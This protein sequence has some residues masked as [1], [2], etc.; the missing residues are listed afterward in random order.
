[1]RELSLIDTVGLSALLVLSLVLPL[2]LGA[3]PS[4]EAQSRK[5][6][7]RWVWG[8]QIWLA[9]L[10][11]LILGSEVAAPYAIGLGLLGCFICGWKLRQSY[12]MKEINE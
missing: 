10:G 7:L 12:R 11:M 2:M 1:M 8:A 6:G 5:A 9:L 3:R 4:V